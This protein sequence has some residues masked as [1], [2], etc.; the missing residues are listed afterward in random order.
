MI[1]ER[2]K[3]ECRVQRGRVQKAEGR[4]WK[5]ESRVHRAECTEQ[6]AQSREAEGRV[7]TAE[8][9]KGFFAVLITLASGSC[10]RC[11]KN[12]ALIFYML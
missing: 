8:C 12:W 6:S 2:Q 5:V 3:A 1:P 7:Q 10:E 4:R 9:G 11:R